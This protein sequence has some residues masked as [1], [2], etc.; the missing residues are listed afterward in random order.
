MGWG[1][2]GVV[3]G[4]IYV[5]TLARRSY[6]DSYIAFKLLLLGIQDFLLHGVCTYRLT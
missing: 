2:V 1:G 6:W 3:V 4:A 5:R